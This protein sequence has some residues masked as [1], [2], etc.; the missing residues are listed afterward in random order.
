VPEG[1]LQALG[2][3]HLGQVE[4]QRDSGKGL[5][6]AGGEKESR[7]HEDAEGFI[8]KRAIG[9][10]RIPH[11]AQVLCHEAPFVQSC[12]FAVNKGIRCKR[13]EV[14]DIRSKGGVKK[15]HMLCRYSMALWHPLMR[16]GS[17]VGALD[18]RAIPS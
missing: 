16:S 4:D 8:E 12:Y 1:W 6:P 14:R 13:V 2:R 3:L 17:L 11:H 15:I 18:P 5:P 10:H 9:F 7:R